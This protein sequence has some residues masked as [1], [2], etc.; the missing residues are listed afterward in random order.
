M[1]AVADRPDRRVG[2]EREIPDLARGQF[3]LCELSLFRHELNFRP[4][5]PGDLRT[6][7]RADLDG[8]Y[9]GTDRDAAQ[10]HGIPDLDFAPLARGQDFPDLQTIRR[11][12]ISLLSV[13]VAEQGDPRRAVGVVFDGGDSPPDVP[14]VTFEIDDAVE[15]LVAP[16]AMAGGDVPVGVPAAGLPQRFDKG[17]FRL[18]PGDVV[19]FLDGHP[20]GAG[21]GRVQFAYG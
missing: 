20:P 12:D 14:L 1:V 18:R 11:E 7:S 4:G 3:Q 15:T 9:R 21:R 8:V 5:A 13:G 16:T 19:E 6:L 2:G 17:F 10:R